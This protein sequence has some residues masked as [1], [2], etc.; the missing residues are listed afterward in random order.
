M[1]LRI[2]SPF[3]NLGPLAEPL[4]PCYTQAA[5]GLESNLT[6]LSKT[7]CSSSQVVSTPR[8]F[9]Y[10][11]FLVSLRTHQGDRS[12]LLG[13]TCWF[14]PVWMLP[15]PSP[16]PAHVSW[17]YCQ[18]EIQNKCSTQNILPLHLW[19]GSGVASNPRTM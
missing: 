9:I 12:A 4:F 18:Q 13:Q 3:Q 5:R 17:L 19:K 10:C 16:P 2:I 11:C 1:N 14:L 15:T 7:I 8:P 6:P